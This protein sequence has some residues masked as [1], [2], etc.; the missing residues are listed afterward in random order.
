MRVL[1]VKL[2]S[3]GDIIHTL[4]AITD[5]AKAIPEIKFT[6]VIDDEFQEIAHWH[7]AVSQVIPVQLRK[8]N[9]GQLFTRLKH[10]RLQKYDL[11]IDAQG[12]IKSSIIARLARGKT[13]VGFDKATCREPL[14][15]YAYQRTCHIDT[16]M[17]AVDRLRLLFAQALGYKLPTTVA[18]Y[19]IKW[20]DF[21]KSH[22][23]Q[24]PYLVFLHGTTWESKHWPDAYWLQ[25]AE[26]VAEKG[27]KVQVTWATPEQNVRAQ[28]LQAYAPNVSMLPHLTIN[29]AAEMLNNAHGIIA[30]DTGFAHLAAAMSKPLVAIYGATQ[31]NKSGA[32]G[33]NC[34]NLASKFSCAPCGKR[35]CSYAGTRELEPACL[36]EITPQ[37]VWDNLAKIIN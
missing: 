3:M 9:I 35:V 29:Q 8:R 31:V 33:Q 6:W 20:R 12:L 36:Q 1:L 22:G 26:L 13:R 4:P 28:R 10:L 11:I 7:D 16:S 37:M 14:A 27:F 24:Q 15:S 21:I 23:Q 34:T 18:D 2:S 17:H 32:V 25:L 30:V 19:G 5:S